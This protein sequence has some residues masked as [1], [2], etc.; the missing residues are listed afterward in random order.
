MESRGKQ[1]TIQRCYNSANGTEYFYILYFYVP[2]FIELSL[3]Q[4]LETVVHELYHI[5][6]DFNGDLRRFQGRC[7]AH[8]SSQKKYDFLVRSLVDQWMKQEPP[9]E[10]WDFLKLGYRE[11]V[12]IYG[13][14]HGTRISMPKIIPHQEQS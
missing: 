6:P 3:T 9:E 10:T 14:L 4:K 1:W 11:L 12:K 8:G 7:V 13:G 5:S 2:R